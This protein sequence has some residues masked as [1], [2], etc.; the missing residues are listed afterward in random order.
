MG[1]EAPAPAADGAGQLRPVPSARFR[2]W[3]PL[4]SCYLL[5]ARKEVITLTRIR[6]AVRRRTQLV[7]G[8]VNPSTRN[9]A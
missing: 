4:A 7:G 1:A 5:V 6:P 2:R 8:L 9:V 3:H